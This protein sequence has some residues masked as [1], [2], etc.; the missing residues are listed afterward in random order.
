MISATI[1]IVDDER[2]ITH[3]VQYKLEAA[4]HRVLVATNGRDAFDAAREHRPNLIITDY[5]MPLMSGLELARALGDD[6]KTSHIPVVMVTGRGHRLPST[7]LQDT[8]IRHLIAK[9]FSPRELLQSVE[10]LLRERQAAS[11][12]SHAA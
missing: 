6:A 10:D 4:G 11:P 1:L 3:V 9:P 12:E 5:Q 8:N 7:D 2:H